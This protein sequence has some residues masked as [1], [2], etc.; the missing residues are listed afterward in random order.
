VL[1]CAF[2]PNP[3]RASG[4]DIHG[5]GTYVVLLEVNASNSKG[6]LG[7]STSRR[8]V[9]A[10]WSMDL[11]RTTAAFGKV[12]PLGPCDVATAQETNRTQADAGIWAAVSHHAYVAGSYAIFLFPIKGTSFVAALSD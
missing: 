1:C 9:S 11:N 7:E 6:R 5:F 4:F 12:G 3:A 10:N 2:G 8:I